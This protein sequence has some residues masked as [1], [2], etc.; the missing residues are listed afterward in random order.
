MLDET[1][2]YDRLIYEDWFG[3]FPYHV[4]QKLQAVAELRQ[5][6]AGETIFQKGDDGS[7]LAAVVTGRVRIC[8]HAPDGRELLI[9]MV[10]RG[11]VFGERAVFDEM[12]RAGDAI[13]ETDMAYLV[14]RRGDLLPAMYSYP[15]TIMYVVKILSHRVVRYMN[16]MELY[17]MQGV[18]ARLANVLLFLGKKHGREQE[19]GVI[20]IG[21]GINQ[22]DLGH[23]VA[24]SRES[25]NRQIKAFA[26]SGLIRLDGNDIVL[27]DLE[28]LKKLCGM[29]G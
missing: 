12:M 13:A 6:K 20:A 18:P 19:G 10:E 14:Y 21:L 11:E 23:L 26:E 9:G 22:T 16:T 4:R 15:D 29:G 27:T 3:M 17:A 28:G 24:T 8:V 1:N 25:V 5:A 7:W 2:L